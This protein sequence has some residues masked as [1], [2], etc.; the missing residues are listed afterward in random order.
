MTIGSAA[1]ARQMGSCRVFSNF[2]GGGTMLLDATA[3]S[4][5]SNVRT[6]R[7]AVHSGSEEGSRPG[8][9]VRQEAGQ[10][11]RTS[12]DV[13]MNVSAATLESSRALSRSSQAADQN[14]TREAV[15]ES[16]R[17]E[18]SAGVRGEPMVRNDLPRQQSVDLVA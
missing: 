4:V 9:E 14:G 18:L 1:E 2:S 7:P 10:T 16:E 11:S 12:P 8:G 13:V 17:R 6:D 5:Q 3:T 15:R